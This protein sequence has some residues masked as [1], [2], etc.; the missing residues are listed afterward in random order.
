MGRTVGQ[1]GSD[2]KWKGPICYSRAA[3]CEVLVNAPGGLPRYT[4]P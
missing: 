1:N 3:A 2:G 4:E